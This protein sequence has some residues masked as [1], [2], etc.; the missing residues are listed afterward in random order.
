MRLPTEQRENEEKKMKEKEHWMQD[1]F[2]KNKGAFRKKAGVKKGEKLTE[3][4][5]DKMEN[6]KGA[7]T[8]TKR[9]A[10]LAKIGMKYGGKK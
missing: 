2:S 7:S 10:N 8:K 1:A 4:K 3:A 6:A 5:A 9:Q